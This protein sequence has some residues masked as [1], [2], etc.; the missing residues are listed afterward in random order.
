MKIND[1]LY[2][3]YESHIDNYLAAYEK[4]G[5][6]D[7]IEEVSFPMLLS[8]EDEDRF[9]KADLR[10]MIFGQETRSWGE[11]LAQFDLDEAWETY[12]GFYYGEHPGYRDINSPFNRFGYTVREH[13]KSE[14]KDKHIEV[15]TN[16]LYKFGKVEGSGRL[17][18]QL[19]DLERAHFDVI[20]KELEI[21]KIDVVA[22]LTGP[23]YDE[24]I[25]QVFPDAKI[26]PYG[27]Y[28]IRSGAAVEA[29]GFFGVRFYHPGYM[30]RLEGCVQD[31]LD[32]ITEVV[33]VAL[34]KK[35]Q[36]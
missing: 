13:L 32:G 19:I 15:I 26:T 11:G 16:N 14:F 3:L 34:N 36:K 17:D 28:E 8:V 5:I 27:L 24:R 33:I 10:V 21:L 23:D 6:V 30:N 31:S 2:G 7:R 20:A 4:A 29:N 35:A 1:R 22:F 9:E 25:K 18:G 12:R